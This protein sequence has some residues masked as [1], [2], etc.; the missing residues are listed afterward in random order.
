MLHKD[1]KNSASNSTSSST[2]DSKDGSDVTSAIRVILIYFPRKIRA[3]KPE[4]NIY[5]FK[6]FHSM[7][8]GI[9]M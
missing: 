5:G 6:N 8:R 9:F 1:I 7:S 4:W 2:D 3:N